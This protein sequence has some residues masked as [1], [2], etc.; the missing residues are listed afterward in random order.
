MGWQYFSLSCDT[1]AC[2]PWFM[3]ELAAISTN[4]NFVRS[5][6]VGGWGDPS[7]LQKYSLFLNHW[8]E[9][10][11]WFSWSNIEWS[12]FALTGARYASLHRDH[13]SFQNIMSWIRYQEQGIEHIDKL[14]LFVFSSMILKCSWDSGNI[15]FSLPC[16]FL[17]LTLLV[18]KPGRS[19]LKNSQ[20]TFESLN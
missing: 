13:I 12:D 10:R 17:P 14:I 16:C 5:V 7:T 19:Y 3:P 6:H 4:L 11:L 1:V 2:T 8:L 15:C 9:N 18:Q 20:G